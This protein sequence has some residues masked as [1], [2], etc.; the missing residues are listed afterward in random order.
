MFQSD[1]YISLFVCFFDI[2]VSLDNL[3]QGIAPVY[4]CFNLSRLNKLFEEI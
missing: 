3:F 2:P 1:G 4:D